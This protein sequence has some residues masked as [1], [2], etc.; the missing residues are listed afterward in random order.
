MA[1]DESRFQEARR[2][3]DSGREDEARVLYEQLVEDGEDRLPS[4]NRLGVLAA[5]RGDSAQAERYFNRCLAIDD[6]YASALS[7]LGNLSFE[8][9][10]LSQ[11]ETF[12][13]LAIAADPKAAVPHR[14]LAAV[15]KKRNDISGMAREMKA[16]N[17]LRRHE[18]TN[19]KGGAIP[20]PTAMGCGTQIVLIGALLAAVALLV[21]LA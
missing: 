20:R 4:L 19:P 12:Y 6:K 7:N 21:H 13:R 2:L 11:A 18:V 16:Y 3:E 1:R 8:R 14:N 9:D 17:R 15:L 5:R 10:D